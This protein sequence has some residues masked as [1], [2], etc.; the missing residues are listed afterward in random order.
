MNPHDEMFEALEKQ[1]QWFRHYYGFPPTQQKTKPSVNWCIFHMLSTWFN[2]G[3]STMFLFYSPEIHMVCR[4]LAGLVLA[5]GGLG[6]MMDFT[7]EVI[8][9]RDLRK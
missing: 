3:V 8:G 4:I 2:F 5:Y 1:Q 9:R 6:S 7:C